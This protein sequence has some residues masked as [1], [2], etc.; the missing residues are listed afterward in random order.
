MREGV[1][2]ASIVDE[3]ENG[4]AK[5]GRKYDR[6]LFGRYKQVFKLLNNLKI[7]KKSF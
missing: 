6:V 1:V 4:E 3:T 5:T 2:N 7:I